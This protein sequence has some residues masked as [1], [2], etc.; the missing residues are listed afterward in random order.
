MADPLG[1]VM[2][3]VVTVLDADVTLQGLGVAGWYEVFAPAKTPAPFGL[4]R[5]LSGGDS[6]T[7]PRRD[8]RLRLLVIGVGTTPT[9][10]RAICEAMD[11]ALRNAAL[12]VSGWSVYRCLPDDEYVMPDMYEGKQVYQRGKIFGIWLDE[13]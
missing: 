10:A 2:G 6:N 1:E 13:N 4:L 5:F 3:A 12:T 9:Q 11:T 7:S 8:V